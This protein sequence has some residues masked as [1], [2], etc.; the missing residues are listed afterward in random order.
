MNPQGL[1]PVAVCALLALAAHAALLLHTAP[2]PRT[3]AT[4]PP[5]AV[6]AR[7]LVEAPIPAPEPV[8]APSPEPEPEH[9][10][11][12]SAATTAAESTATASPPEAPPPAFEGDLPQIGF[13][14][15]P[16]P[17]QGVQLRAYVELQPDGNPRQVSTAS[18]PGEPPPPVGFQK[19]AELGLRQAHFKPGLH[20]AYCLLIRFEADT[21][22]PQLAWLPGAERDATRCLAGAL[23][24]PRE[25]VAPAP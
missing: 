18:A 20:P 2:D 19:L 1:K 21:P 17:P 16:L 5:A 6:S 7:V 12:A 8:Q 25:I 3:G 23:P 22:A 10:A 24:A 13:P 9:T 11:Q 15:A 14:D 4:S